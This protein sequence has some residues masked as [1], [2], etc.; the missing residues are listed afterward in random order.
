[1]NTGMDSAAVAYI[2][3]HPATWLFGAVV[4]IAIIIQINKMVSNHINKH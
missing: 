3:S 4:L 1:M 2:L